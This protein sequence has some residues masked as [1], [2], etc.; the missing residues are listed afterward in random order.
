MQSK[1]SKI[2]KSSISV[3]NFIKDNFIFIFFPREAGGN[4]LKTLIELGL[5]PHQEQKENINKIKTLL[6]KDGREG[7]HTD[8][9]IHREKPLTHD[10]L[11]KMVQRLDNQNKH[12][13]FCDMYFTFSTHELFFHLFDVNK[14][15]IIKTDES[16]DLL[17]DRRKKHNKQLM[18]FEEIQLNSIF[19]KY[20]KHEFP[21]AKIIEIEFKDLRKLE[22]YVNNLEQI[23]KTFGTEI[24]IDECKELIQIYLDKV[25]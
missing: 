2:P 6:D 9:L 10:F 1:N 7:F 24:P 22:T 19:P 5:T 23:K 13:V 20:M 16:I 8:E 11:K 12:L 21:N 14:F 15:I 3:K 18:T 17:N 25:I 4:F